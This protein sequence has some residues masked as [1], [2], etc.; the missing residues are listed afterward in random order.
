MTQPDLALRPAPHRPADPQPTFRSLFPALREKTY[1]SICDKMILAHPVRAGVDRFLDKLAHA[2]A[3]RVDHEVLVE[4]GREKFARLVNAAPASIAV[5]R[6]VSDGINALAWA[7]PLREGDNIVIATGAE[8]PNNIYPWLRQQERGVELRVVASPDG[9]IDPKA[10]IAAAD[11]RT[12]IVTAASVSFSPGYRTDLQALGEFCRPKDIFLL[13]DGVQSAGI[14]H[15]DFAAEPIDGFATSTSKG[16]LGLYGYGFAYV[17]PRWIDRMK[18]V[19]LSRTGIALDTDDASAMGGLDYALKPDARRF[20]LGSYNLAGAYA[21][22]AALGLLLDIGTRTI[23][24]HVLGLAE[25]LRE[26]LDALGVAVGLPRTPIE[27][28]HIITCGTLDNGG[29]GFSHDPA[30]TE[31][32]HR[33]TDA[34]VTLTLRRGQLRFGLHYYNDMSDIERVLDIIATG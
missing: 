19:Y 8:H 34:G 3:S 24:Q 33:L 6:N 27:R 14:L 12:R 13:V 25:A 21:A 30:I 16:L 22:D 1:L 18:P 11:A 17:A 29:H 20:E 10:M 23:E 5:M 32:Y 9:R 4:S 28:A 15:H 31:L 26:G 7:F 2:G